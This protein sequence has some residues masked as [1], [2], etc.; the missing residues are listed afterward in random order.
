MIDFTLCL[1]YFHYTKPTPPHVQP[2]QTGFTPSPSIHASLIL[3][4][5]SSSRPGTT[6]TRT[7]SNPV[8]QPLT[9][10]FP[11]PDTAASNRS[12]STV[13]PK[14]RRHADY[15]SSSTLDSP[16]VYT[17]GSYAALY[18]AALDVAR[19]AE[20][21]ERVNA[22]RSESRRRQLSRRNTT[23]E[24]GV[25]GMMESFHS[26]MSR[27]TSSTTNHEDYRRMALS[28]GDLLEGRGRSMKR[29]GTVTP[30]ETDDQATPLASAQTLHHGEDVR[31]TAR[32]EK[33]RSL[34]LARNTSG[35]GGRRVA[36]V[37][38]MSM[39]LLFRGIY[40]SEPISTG[41]SRSGHVLSPAAM[42]TLTYR[43]PPIHSPPVR[44][45][46]EYTFV[47]FDK[48]P[49]IP[50]QPASYV[51]MVG[52]VSAWCCTTLYLTSRLPQIW[53]NASESLGM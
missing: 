5:R 20:R 26:D 17:D 6:R 24:E 19:A 46:P 43:H 53:K 14:P 2:I 33:S 29:V 45:T 1:Q 47:T 22:R 48:H 38:F 40:S 25:E 36:G 16:G 32:R 50:D 31:G 41:L 4:A 52:R 34:S 15:G 11:Q 12:H 21:V 7:S 28:T 42:T 27:N 37:A 30:G 8:V 49:P 35:R 18:E 51:R 39:G 13:R 3:P 10:V 44:P 9:S 23:D